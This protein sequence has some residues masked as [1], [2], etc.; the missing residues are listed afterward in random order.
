VQELFLNILRETKFLSRV[1]TLIEVFETLN[2]TD[3]FKSNFAQVKTEYS[4]GQ[5]Y[6]YIHEY[7]GW[8]WVPT[9]PHHL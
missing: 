3:K 6:I 8:N 5:I 4:G 2:E 1:N 7:M 9:H